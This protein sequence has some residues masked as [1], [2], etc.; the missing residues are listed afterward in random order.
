M[1]APRDNLRISLKGVD[2]TVKS[3]ISLL[4][5]TDGEENAL[6]SAI[7]E[8]KLTKKELIR[9]DNPK[10]C[11]CKRSTSSLL[12][13]LV[14]KRQ[15]LKQ[16]AYTVISVRTIW[17]EKENASLGWSRKELNV[18]GVYHTKQ[19]A[20]TVRRR[21]VQGRDVSEESPKCSTEII[22]REDSQFTTGYKGE[23]N[24]ARNSF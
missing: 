16:N 7:T 18:V 4:H 14:K 9:F 19:A 2:D 24:S 3:I 1:I 6:T 10:S 11:Y 5:D 12:K 8:E 15:L 20:E 17:N 23:T 21:V 22:I 13:P